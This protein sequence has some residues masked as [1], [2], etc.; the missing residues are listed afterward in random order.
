MIGRGLEFAHLRDPF[1]GMGRG[2]VT[3]FRFVGRAVSDS[4]AGETPAWESFYSVSLNR[5][6]IV[7]RVSGWWVVGVPSESGAMEDSPP[8][9]PGWDFDEDPCF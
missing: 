1:A 6:S 8:Y 2:A 3:A 5:R 9:G 4:G 7:G